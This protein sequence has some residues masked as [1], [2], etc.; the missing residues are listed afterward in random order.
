MS[1]KKKIS[2]YRQGVE[3]FLATLRHEIGWNARLGGLSILKKKHTM[4]RVLNDLYKNG[5]AFH[6]NLYIDNEL[7]PCGNK[8]KCKHCEECLNKIKV[9]Q[10]VNEIDKQI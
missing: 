7:S 6:K 5:Y 10:F 8:F 1:L 4:F 2:T 3:C 9:E